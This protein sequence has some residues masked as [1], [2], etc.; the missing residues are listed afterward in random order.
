MKILI[1]TQ[2]FIWLINDD[3]QLGATAKIS[4]GDAKNHLHISY[5]SFWEM[6]IKASIGK[7]Q[8]D[9][10][11]LDDLPQMGIDLIMPIESTLRSYTIYNA[12]NKDPFDNMIITT[13]QTDN[14]TLLTSDHKILD[15]P[16]RG[17]TTLDA[18]N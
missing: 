5:F 1:D 11:I 2:V 3:P 17:L 9:S 4:L 14:L 8:Y 10:S 16:V 6:A 15:T 12:A 18:R 13:A 7:L